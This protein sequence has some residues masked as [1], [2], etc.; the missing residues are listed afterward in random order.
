MRLSKH[1]A[2]HGEQLDQLCVF[3]DRQAQVLNLLGVPLENHEFTLLPGAE[4]E[5]HVE[6]ENM[7]FGEAL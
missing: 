1:S 4:Q 6:V 2:H 3:I 5:V 7:T